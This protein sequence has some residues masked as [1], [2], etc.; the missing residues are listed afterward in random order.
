MR[1][2]VTGLSPVFVCALADGDISAKTAQLSELKKRRTVH[3][4]KGE[5][6]AVFEIN[7]Y[8][9]TCLGTLESW[10]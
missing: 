8:V 1:I 2:P 5:F 3:H 9:T 4:I 7:T 10:A 6:W